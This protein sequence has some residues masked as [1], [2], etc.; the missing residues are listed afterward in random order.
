MGFKVYIQCKRVCDMIEKQSH[1]II[2]KSSHNTAHSFD[3]FD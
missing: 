2:Q 3:H 1:C